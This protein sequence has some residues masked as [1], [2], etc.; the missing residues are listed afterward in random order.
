MVFTMSNS[1]QDVSKFLQAICGDGGGF[2][3]ISYTMDSHLK[4]LRSEFFNAT[5]IASIEK[6]L[7]SLP[8]GAQVVF[9]FARIANDARDLVIA[10]A[11]IECNSLNI[12]HDFG[13]L[14]AFSCYK[15][16]EFVGYIA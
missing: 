1:T 14:R 11:Q 15:T 8:S 3:S 16:L 7:S 9:N 6:H 13:E 4:S 12:G 2:V 10:F 5:D